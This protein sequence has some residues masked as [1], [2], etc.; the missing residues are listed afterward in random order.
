[1]PPKNLELNGNFVNNIAFASKYI[2][3]NSGYQG[4]YKGIVPNVIKTGFGSAIFFGSLRFME[5]KFENPNSTKAAF[6]SSFIARIIS[7]VTSN[8]LSVLETR[9]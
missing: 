4:F 7:A 2:V 5:K 8:P 6:I 3:N 1:M 9:Y